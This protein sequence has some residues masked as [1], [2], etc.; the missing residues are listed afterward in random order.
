MDLYRYFHPHHNPRLLRTPLRLQE[1]GELEQ[2]ASE[3]KKAI[4]RAAIRS[5]NASKNSTQDLFTDP[6]DEELLLPTPHERSVEQRIRETESPRIQ[7]ERLTEILEAL[8]FVV[9]S[10]S[11]L[12]DQHPG[13]ESATMRALLSERVDAP[14]WENWTRLLEQRLELLTQHE[15]QTPE[16]LRGN[17]SKSTQRS[18]S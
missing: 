14:G 12:S 4:R 18:E 7:L 11:G 1:L 15:E 3:L 2:A 17:S 10:L 6:S 13:D 16:K 8:E 5:E 9:D